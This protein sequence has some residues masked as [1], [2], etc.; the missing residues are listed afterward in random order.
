MR[1]NYKPVL[2]LLLITPLLTELLSNNMSPQVFFNPVVFLLLTTVVYGFPVLLLREFAC[3]YR[4]G[5]SGLLCL[6]LV[7]G[8]IN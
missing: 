4:L 8:I 7:Y 3:Q 2:T 1:A 5:I 6:G